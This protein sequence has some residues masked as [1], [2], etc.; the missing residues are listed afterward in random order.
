VH[1]ERREQGGRAMAFVVVG[2]RRQSAPLH[3]QTGLCS[4]QR[5]DLMGW[6]APRGNAVPRCWPSESPGR[7][8]AP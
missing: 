2:H 8:H 7:S 4:V 3:R 5:L 6:M 1:V